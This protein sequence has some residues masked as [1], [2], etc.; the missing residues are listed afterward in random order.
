MINLLLQNNNNLSVLGS[1]GT[2]LKHVGILIVE[3]A[4]NQYISHLNGLGM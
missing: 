4:D 2:H 1:A 3:K